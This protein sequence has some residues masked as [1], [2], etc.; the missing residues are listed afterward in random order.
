MAPCLAL[1]LKNTHDR[2]SQFVDGVGCDWRRNK[3]V[4]T[5]SEAEPGTTIAAFQKGFLNVLSG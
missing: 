4:W 1:Y 5:Y 2:P 3:R